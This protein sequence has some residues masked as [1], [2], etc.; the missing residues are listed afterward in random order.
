MIENVNRLAVRINSF[1]KNDNTTGSGVVYKKDDKEDVYIITCAH[2]VYGCE[3]IEIEYT[4][5]L[6]IYVEKEDVYLHPNYKYVKKT[7]YRN[8]VIENDIAVIRVDKLKFNEEYICSLDD[9][10]IKDVKE[11]KLNDEFIFSGFMGKHKEAKSYTDCNKFYYVKYTSA[12]DSKSEFL[13]RNDQADFKD[14]EY[15]GF[16]GSGVYR[17]YNKKLYLVGVLSRGFGENAE[18]KEL[19]ATRTT[20]LYDFLGD[21]ENIFKY[22]D[23]FITEAQVFNNYGL[24]ILTHGQLALMKNDILSDEQDLLEDFNEHFCKTI[25]LC[26]NLECPHK[27]KKYMENVLALFT[28]LYDYTDGMLQIKEIESKYKILSQGD[29]LKKQIKFICNDGFIGERPTMGAMVHQIKKNKLD[30]QE[31]MDNTLIVWCSN[32]EA[33]LKLNKYCDKAGF[34]K[35]IDNLIKSDIEI[36]DYYKRESSNTVKNIIDFENLK[37]ISVVH[38]KYFDEIGNEIEDIASEREKKEKLRK[39][40]GKLMGD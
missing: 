20:C 22:E 32:D 13:F 2:V 31:I 36:F 35:I 5:D 25:E 33:K 3:H 19:Y 24:S 17:I 29:E 27:C 14:T 38:V 37:D 9:I 16:S 18:N 21:F 15:R 10:Y 23:N 40:F 28:L 30:Q 39:L 12:T 6:S 34:E 11:Y 8:Q 26:E 1:S 7:D 4:S